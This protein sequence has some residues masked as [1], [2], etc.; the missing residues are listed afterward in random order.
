MGPSA[1]REG[2]AIR[3]QAL[4]PSALAGLV[5]GAWIA[6]V[7][8]AWQVALWHGQP[9]LDPL[10]FAVPAWIG[11][12]WIRSGAGSGTDVVGLAVLTLVAAI[13]GVGLDT[14]AL[15]LLL[16]G[17]PGGAV[18]SHPAGLL[19][20][21]AVL[22][23]ARH[24]EPALEDVVVG[25]LLSWAVPGLALPWIVGGS[26]AEPWRSMFVQAAFPATLLLVTAGLLAIG[27]ARLD[28]LARVAGPDW[29]LRRSWL[30]LATGVLAVM[31][32]V[33]VPA[34]FLLGAPLGSVVDGLLGPLATLL[35]LLL[36][37]L[38]ALGA[39]I[40][41]LLQ[42]VPLHA[43]QP[44]AA[45]VGGRAAPPVV[46]SPAADAAVA[47]GAGFLVVI[48]FLVLIYLVARWDAGRRRHT[49]ASDAAAAVPEERSL[50][51]PPGGFAL[52]RWGRLRAPR[53]PTPGD[54]SGAYLAWLGQLER[55]PQRQRLASETPALHAARLRRQGGLPLAADLLAA[56]F[57]LERYGQR[58]LGIL[59]TRRA[60]QRW[61]RLRRAGPA[62]SGR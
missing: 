59:E 45:P 55:Q 5:E 39:A 43:V 24:R 49:A 29:H 56:D 15:G 33:A 14:T 4:V 3:G 22:R 60:L 34:A 7:Y 38:L 10:A 8:A 20:G 61:R 50:A 46:T 62:G 26:A 6:T 21:L 19:A 18:A 35:G 27:L 52:P 32:L 51:L 11:L 58:R 54:A 42:F 2:L 47:V 16:G 53:Q 41:A 28:E 36:L 40:V 44:S 25:R 9:I 12:W 30:L 31:G 57:E 23:G 37:P 13:V 1:G 48:G 17:D